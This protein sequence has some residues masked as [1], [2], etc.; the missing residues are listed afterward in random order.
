M[1]E[2]SP[3][4]FFDVWHTYQ[5]VVGANHMFHREFAAQLSQFLYARFAIEPFPSSILA[6]AMRQPW[7][8]C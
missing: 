1:S 3:V 4:A 7:P 6:A 2:S 8:P 5:K